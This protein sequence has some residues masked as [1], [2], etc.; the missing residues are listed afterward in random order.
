MQLRY[1]QKDTNVLTTLYKLVTMVCGLVV[2][3]ILDTSSSE[4]KNP[5]SKSS[6]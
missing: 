2:T 6:G 1:P 5:Q 4:V 3:E